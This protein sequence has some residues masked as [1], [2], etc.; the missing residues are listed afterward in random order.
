[1]SWRGR[2]AGKSPGVQQVV[3]RPPL[4]VDLSERGEWAS[5]PTARFAFSEA[6]ACKGHHYRSEGEGAE[7]G[8]GTACSESPRGPAAL[9]QPSFSVSRAGCCLDVFLALAKHSFS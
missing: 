9:A 6:L 4:P 3:L 1:M 8:G 2:Q 5:D 7:L